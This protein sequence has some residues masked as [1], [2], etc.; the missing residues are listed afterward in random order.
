[1]TAKMITA[2]SCAALLVYGGPAAAQTDEIIV[3]AKKRDESIQDVNISVTA[4][5]GDDMK[6]YSFDTADDIAQQTSNL[7]TV[8]LFGNNLPNFAIRGV[9]LND[10]APNNSSPTAVHVDE[11]FYP[12][13]VMLNFG[14]FDMERVEVLKGP[15]GT[16]YGRNTTAGAVSFFSRRPDIDE[17]SAEITAGYGNYQNF[18]TSGFINAPLGDRAAFR[19]SGD[20]RKQSDG[21]FYNRNLGQ[22]H[23]E[24]ERFALRGQLN[25]QPTDDFEINLNV[26]G[27]KETS[28]L[29]Q[30]DMLPSG[31]AALDGFCDAFTNGT[32]MGGEPDCFDLSLNQEPDT[33]PFTSAPGFRPSLNLEGIGG[34]ATIEW[35]AGPVILT[36]ITGLE[37]FEREVREDAD[38]FSQIIVDDYYVNDIDV[39]SQEV[40]FTSDYDGPFQWIAGLYYQ[41]DSLDSPISEVKAYTRGV[42]INTQIFQD[43]ETFAA[44]G[45]A[46]YQLSPMWKLSGGLRYT[47]EKRDFEGRTFFDVFMMPPTVVSFDPPPPGDLQPFGVP[48]SERID[49]KE[50]NNISGKVALDFTPD[51]NTLIYLSASRGF[52][53]GGFNGNLAL[54]DASITDFDEEEVYAFELGKKLTLANG[55]LRWNSA[56]FW[57]EYKDAQ[58]LGNFLVDTGGG[59]MG[60]IF[61]LNNL[62]DARIAGFE[63]DIQ[64]SPTPEWDIRG[65]IGVLDT[66]IKNSIEPMNAITIG[67]ELSFAPPVNANGSVRYTTDVA[68]GYVGSVQVDVT[69][70]AKFFTN[71]SNIPVTESG[72]YTLVNGRASLF[73]SDQGWHLSFWARNI[74]N[75][76]YSTWVNNLAS[77]YRVLRATG[78]PRT[79][80]VELSYA[81][82]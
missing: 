54:N 40:R 64:W 61:A 46:E 27:G 71:I 13:A 26:H 1:M 22:N 42:A 78:M 45:N 35:D 65:G 80:G 51:D 52:K 41:T 9:G 58:L 14:L 81:F 50:F 23:G 62:A 34:V 47:H 24:I 12:F 75:E 66:Q 49:S 6:A 38:G 56:A 16:L 32:L 7:T 2:A 33:D 69:H 29:A 74:F 11:V 77:T 67:E 28:D 44:F 37:H 76:E 57:Y 39:F 53:S 4:I 70:S 36:S 8:N 19:L 55:T 3:S 68:N 60:N 15:Q 30:Y 25:F 59:V 79:F 31:N 43:T 82:N 20:Y 17:F 48:A 5:S 21:P 18:E 10:I 63:S 73:A 72:G